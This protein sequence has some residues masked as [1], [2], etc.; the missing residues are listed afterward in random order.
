[1]EIATGIDYMAQFN[2]TRY[3]AND[4]SLAEFAR[5]NN[6]EVHVSEVSHRRKHGIR[7]G[8]KRVLPEGL[9]M[10]NDNEM[11]KFYRE[12]VKGQYS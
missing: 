3:S 6:I 10:N 11:A 2:R 7:L 1:M 9:W 5:V 12:K 8:G 4:N